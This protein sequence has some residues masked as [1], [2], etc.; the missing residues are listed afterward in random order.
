MGTVP[1]GKQEAIEWYEARVGGW[2]EDP[3]AVGLTPAMAA[4][5]RARLS[6]ARE[7][8]NRA[9]KLCRQYHAAIDQQDA[10]LAQLRRAG[11]PAI[12]TVR[13]FAAMGP[14]IT[15]GRSEAEVLAHAQLAAIR[16]PAPIPAAP[17]SSLRWSLGTDGA[18]TLRWDGRLGTGTSYIVE[19]ALMPSSG[20]HAGRLGAFGAV[21]MVQAKTMKDNSFPAGTAAAAYQVR[22][23]KGGEL[24]EPSAA[25]VARLAPAWPVGQAAPRVAA[26]GR[27]PSAR[28]PS[29]PPVGAGRSGGLVS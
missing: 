1:L 29:G 24:T 2:E 15:G 16:D 7:S 13:G 22:A 23:L 6:A 5:V 4:A 10:D 12:Q 18:L 3:A 28:A 26:A 27:G 20:P 21:G 17:A 14:A 11:T 9:Q 25:V 19:R 8:Y